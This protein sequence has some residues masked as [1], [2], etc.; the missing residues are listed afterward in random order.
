MTTTLR[1][2]CGFET[3]GLDEASSS[4][5][6]PAVN[7]T[8][9]VRSGVYSLKI[10]AS[11]SYSLSEGYASSGVGAGISADTRIL[12]GFAVQWADITPSAQ[13]TFF[14]ILDGNGVALAWLALATTG[15]LILINANGQTIATITPA[16]SGLAINTWL[17]IELAVQRDNSGSWQLWIGGVSKGSGTSDFNVSGASFGS[18]RFN[19]HPDT[20]TVIDDVYILGEDATLPTPYGPSQVFAY[21][22]AANTNAADAGLTAN[23]SALG[24]GQVWQS[25]AQTPYSTQFVGY[26][27]NPADGATLFNDAGDGSGRGPGPSGGA[28]TVNGTIRGAKWF[29]YYLRGGGGGS[30]HSM[31]YGNGTD[32]PIQQLSGLALA[33]STATRGVVSA[34]AN[35]VPTASEV[36]AMG[37][38]TGGAQDITCEEQWAFLLHTPPHLPELEAYRWYGTG[39]QS[40]AAAL[41]AQDTA[42]DLDVSGGDVIVVLRVRVQE[43]GGTHGATTDDW[44]L[45]VNA[46]G[47]GWLNLID[48]G[49][50]GVYAPFGGSGLTDGG[51][52]TSRLSA[53]SGSFIAG[54]QEGMDGAF[55]N[56]QLTADNYTEHVIAVYFYEPELNHG[57]IFQFRI[58]RNGVAITSDVIPTV[59]III[60]SGSSI[61][62]KMHQY[63]M[64]RAA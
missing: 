5:G 25:A 34:A 33:T 44:V 61:P 14:E 29:G 41:A 57:D 38:G 45:Q 1:Q 32:T 2:I 52:T 9:P 48:Q 12:V 37:F 62:P 19:G 46:K 26:T 64:R 24:P 15:N 47:E 11:S 17:H 27:A 20:N 35:A 10:P 53:G 55:D 51:A 56:Y 42:L 13:F 49:G 40:G 54:I 60:P 63:R 59:N 31:Y 30:T 8:A 58:T 4:S 22:G 23:N 6:S 36:F 50:D 3:G 28:Y 7:T 21:Q 43:R 16:N 39:T 18:I